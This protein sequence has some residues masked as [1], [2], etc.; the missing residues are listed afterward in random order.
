MLLEFPIEVLSALVAGRWAASASA[1][2]PFL[3]GYKLRLGMAAIVTALVRSP[4]CAV[5][6]QDAHPLSHVQA[7]RGRAQHLPRRRAWW[8]HACLFARVCAALC[9]YSLV[10]LLSFDNL[11]CLRLC[12]R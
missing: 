12:W 7:L 4:S 3:A 9:I 11:T 8:I 10:A 6:D 1:A 5:S 2:R